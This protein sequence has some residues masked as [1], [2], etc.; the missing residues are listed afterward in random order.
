VPYRQERLNFDG[1]VCNN[2]F[3]YKVVLGQGNPMYENSKDGIHSR[4]LDP[5]DPANNVWIPDSVPSVKGQSWKANYDDGTCGKRDIDDDK[6][7]FD[8]S[9]PFREEPNR[10]DCSN[11]VDNPIHPTLPDK[12][13]GHETVVY[14]R[15]TK[16]VAISRLTDDYL[17]TSGLVATYEGELEDGAVLLLLAP[18]SKPK[19]TIHFLGQ[20][21]QNKLALSTNLLYMTDH[22]PKQ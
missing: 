11:I 20:Y 19:K 21:K 1:E 14:Q 5:N 3:E 15:R 7:H 12:R 10:G 4:F 18:G 16:Y 2:P 22:F 8:P 17:D 13:R 6:H 9:L